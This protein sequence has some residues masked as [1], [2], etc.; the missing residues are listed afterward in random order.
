MMGGRLACDSEVGKGSEFCFSIELKEIVNQSVSDKSLQ[1]LK[2]LIVDDNITNLKIFSDTLKSWGCNFQK[3]TNGNEALA[4]MKHN[5]SKGEPFD[6]LLIDK[7]MPIMDGI[8]LSKVIHHDDKIEKPV[9]I[10]VSSERVHLSNEELAEIG[11]SAYLTKPIRNRELLQVI[12]KT[13]GVEYNPKIDSS[14]NTHR[15]YNANILVAEDNSVNQKVVHAYLS[16]LGCF[17]EVVE[18]GEL[19]LEAVKNKEYDLIFMDCN[20]PKC[21]GFQATKLIQKYQLDNNIKATP[22]IALTANAMRGDKEMCLASGMSDYLSKPFQL[23]NLEAILEQWLQESKSSDNVEKE[24]SVSEYDQQ[25]INQKKITELKELGEECGTDLLGEVVGHYLDS[26]PEQIQTI[27]T[28][29]QNNDAQVVFAEAHSMKSSSASL[30]ADS[31]AKLCA[32]L[33]AMGKLEEMKNM[34]ALIAKIRT[35]YGRVESVLKK[36]KS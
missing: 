9:V 6:L 2:I 35:E 8:E 5:Q 19:A 24:T 26:F 23:K 32:E 28:G 20:M 33:E 15:L 27:S 3:A 31:M 1:S 12:S 21:D 30:G 13:T 29:L 7:C 17:T 16:K 25:I 10:I 22:I 11:V 4:I 18:N 36:Y 34:M 14:Q